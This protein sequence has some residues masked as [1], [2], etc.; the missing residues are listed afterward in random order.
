[1]LAATLCGLGSALVPGLVHASAPATAPEATPSVTSERDAARTRRRGKRFTALEIQGIVT[2]EMV[3]STFFGVDGALAIGNDH[4]YF[5]AGGA[6]LG[7]PSFRLASNDVSNVLAYG[8][9]DVCA[10]KTARRHRLRMCV[11]AEVGGWAHR[12]SGYGKPGN[13][14]S[15]H[16]AGTLKAD[17]RYAFTDTVGLLLGVGVSIPAMGPQFRG[18]DQ[19]GRPTPLLIPGP[20][21]GS[22]R[23]GASFRFG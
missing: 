6:V 18:R 9:A 15:P 21:S 14:Y 2:R 4:F 20:V 22:L 19:F 10:G 16:V 12:W 5:R 7:A 3:P 23:L 1:M 11:G 17:Y 8:L 13:R